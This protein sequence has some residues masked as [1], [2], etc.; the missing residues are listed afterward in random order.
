MSQF[1]ACRARVFD[2]VF[3]LEY[4]NMRKNLTLTVTLTLNH[5]VDESHKAYSSEFHNHDEIFGIKQLINRH[6]C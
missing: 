3:D 1:D 2:L 4:D 6:V 5:Y